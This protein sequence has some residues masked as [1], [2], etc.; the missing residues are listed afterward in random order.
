MSYSLSRFYADNYSSDVSDSD[1]E[2][3]YDNFEDL[4]CEWNE[5]LKRWQDVETNLMVS[6]SEAIDRNNA[7]CAR[8]DEINRERDDREDWE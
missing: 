2:Y 4:P 3:D 5:K 1:V 6:E 7:E 8:Q